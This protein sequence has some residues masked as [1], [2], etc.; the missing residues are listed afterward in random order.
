M[1]RLIT[2]VASNIRRSHSLSEFKQF[3]FT[4]LSEGYKFKQFDFTRGDDMPAFIESAIESAK[5]SKPLRALVKTDHIH[6]SI[7]NK[8]IDLYWGIR[9]L[10]TDLYHANIGYILDHKNTGFMAIS[11]CRTCSSW[12]SSKKIPEVLSKKPHHEIEPYKAHFNPYLLLQY[13]PQK[14]YEIPEIIFHDN[15]DTINECLRKIRDF[16]RKILQG[17]LYRPHPDNSTLPML[18]LTRDGLDKYLRDIVNGESVVPSKYYN[19]DVHPY[20]KIGRDI[21]SSV[22]IIDLPKFT[23]IQLERIFNDTTM[24]FF[25][26]ASL[27]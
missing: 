21:G 9:S 26:K 10:S 14:T 25:A 13:E 4:S 27:Q 19:S 24:D 23:P 12:F 8:Y 3:D 18:E 11:R 16:N 7:G 2:R 1:I 22:N 17:L 6:E 20:S 15:H 5:I